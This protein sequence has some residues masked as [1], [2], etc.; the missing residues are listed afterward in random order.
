M[1]FFEN[2]IVSIEHAQAEIVGKGIA[3]GVG[4]LFVRD[5][6][7]MVRVGRPGCLQPIDLVEKAESGSEVARCVFF[8]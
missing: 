7:S 3:K 1:R 2:R 8:L 6:C 4:E 5:V